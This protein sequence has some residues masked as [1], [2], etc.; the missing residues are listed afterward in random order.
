MHT[1]LFYQISSKS[2]GMAGMIKDLNKRG[3]FPRERK[4]ML[5]TMLCNI[6]DD[7]NELFN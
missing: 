7:L 3:L 5:D 2:W 6:N 1:F 4:D